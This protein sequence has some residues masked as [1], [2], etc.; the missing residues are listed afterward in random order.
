MSRLTSLFSIGLMLMVALPALAQEPDTQ[1]T[2]TDSQPLS[3]QSLDAL[4]AG[5]ALYPDQT[6]QEALAASIH[7]EAIEA[8][9]A[10]SPEQ[11][12]AQSSQFDASIQYLQANEP[13]LLQQL[14]QHLSLT[15]SLGVAAQTQLND[16]W[17]SVD[18]VRAQYQQ[19]TNGTQDQ[20]STDENQDNSSDSASATGNEASEESAP[21][22]NTYNNNSSTTTGYGTTGYGGAGAFAAGLVAGN[23]WQDLYRGRPYYP[24]NRYPDNH[25]LY[26]NGNNISG[27]NISGNNVIDDRH[28]AANGVGGVT[29]VNG[30]GRAGGV[31]GIGGVA[32]VGGVN[33]IGG[34]A[35]AGGV[36]GVG[37]FN[38]ARPADVKAGNNDWVNGI[39]AG[40]RQNLTSNTWGHMD[41]QAHQ[42]FTGR[43]GSPAN[44]NNGPNTGRPGAN[45]GIGGGENGFGRPGGAGSNPANSQFGGGFGPSQGKMSSGNSSQPRSNAGQGHDASPSR[46]FGGAGGA[47][48][49]GGGNRGGAGGGR[50]GGGRR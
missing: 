19:S 8:A 43:N 28:P 22:Y 23:A 47:G 12:Q 17:T 37:G 32:G 42:S 36:N 5:I 34:V 2:P 25:N 18:R 6:V 9:A 1:N 31:N 49:A 46:S 11:F 10:L 50:A 38:T 30:V 29:G 15:T 40:E 20:Q 41:N 27:N 26:R 4:T 33:G 39:G 24:A 21:T 16:V 35:G 45:N 14:N 3:P 13:A 44:F 7:P 48:G